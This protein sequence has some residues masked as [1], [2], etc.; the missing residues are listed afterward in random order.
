VDLWGKAALKPL[1]MPGGVVLVAA[2]IFLQ[3]G[4][5]PPSAS[6]IATYYW[7][8]FLAGFLLAWR[9]HSSRALLAVVLLLIS[10]RAL[11]FFSAGRAVAN[12]PSRIA[13][14]AVAVLLPLNFL[15][16]TMARERGFT[17]SS[18]TSWLGIFFVESVVVAVLCRPGATTPPWFLDHGFLHGG[19]FHG[20]KLP[21]LAWTI[22]AITFILLLIRPFSKNKPI[23]NGL[24]WSLAAAFLGLQAGGAGRMGSAYF[25]TAALILA[26]SMI[27]NSYV[28]A[29]H[30][31]LTALPAR[32]AFNDALLRLQN[33]YTIATVDIDHFKR[34][35]DTFGHETG[36]QVLRMV[37]TKLARASGEGQAFRVGGEE[38]ILLFPG[39]SLPDVLPHL[40]ILRMEIEASAFHVRGGQ[41]RRASP[42]GADRRKPVVSKRKTLRRKPA[43]KATG[44]FSV[45]VSIGAAE[46]NAQTRRVEQVIQSSDKALYRA[47][48]AGRNRV[49]VAAPERNRLKRNIA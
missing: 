10:H 38:F 28:L 19:G 18:L 23:E 8:A 34:F 26:C 35:N 47:K 2:V 20:T 40:E 7:A 4:I 9:F 43:P 6:V 5:F 42:H 13:L 29:Y 49:E 33:P 11:E 41:E 39:E 36:D 12:G 21:Q 15:F 24:L 45:T 48:R 3:G 30:D 16:L 31:E 46:S 27:E 44:E 25:A 37:A 14:E 32:R 17:I 22:F 1:L